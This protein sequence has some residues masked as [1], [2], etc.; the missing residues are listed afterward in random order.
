MTFTPARGGSEPDAEITRFGEALAA[1][2]FV[3]KPE[4]DAALLDAYASALDAYEAA[5]RALRG[6]GTAAEADTAVRRAL[7][8]GRQAL[9]DLDALRAGRPVCRSSSPC[10]FDSRHGP[11][12]GEVPY[13]PPGDVVRMIAVCAADA[14]RLRDD[15]APFA[16]G[17]APARRRGE[18]S[19]PAA[20]KPAAAR[21]ERPV[22]NTRSAQGAPDVRG[23]RSGG[24]VGVPA[25][26]VVLSSSVPQEFSIH[27]EAP[28]P[29]VLVV[30][31]VSRGRPLSTTLRQL[32]GSAG[33]ARAQEVLL[34]A[35]GDFT[36]RLPMA[37]GGTAS[38]RFG[39]SDSATAGLPFGG[40]DVDAETIPYWE[41]WVGSVGS[42]REFGTSVSG[43]GWDVVRYTGG[44]TTAW[45]THTGR[46]GEVVIKRLNSQ[47]QVVEQLFR[48]Y[49]SLKDAQLAM[50]A[51]PAWLA[52][53]CQGSWSLAV[54]P[55]RPTPF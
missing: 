24:R 52:V 41:G 16:A 27:W 54:H 13:T 53:Q 11:S 29:A 3:P 20:P 38:A 28:G 43:V 17:R 47:L 34:K 35:G 40:W 14:V 6:A 5:K 23:A 55:A 15:D 22:R 33:P 18:R 48:G 8:E 26:K 2:D 10:F 45:F 21:S 39:I 42:C 50:P 31:G 4:H 51:K 44:R 9:E 30:R 37:G 46:R 25:R 12:V 36:A 49:R 19:R 32:R 1:Y 7:G